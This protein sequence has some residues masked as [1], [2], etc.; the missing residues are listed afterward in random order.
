MGIR[1]RVKVA[2][3]SIDRTHLALA[4]AWTLITGAALWWHADREQ[5]FSEE[6][7]S[8]LADVVTGGVLWLLGLVGIGWSNRRTMLNKR[9]RRRAD[10]ALNE[11][12]KM[13][14]SLFE[15]AND[16]VYVVDG[17]GRYLDVNPRACA[18]TGHTYDELIALSIPDLLVSESVP[19]GLRLFGELVQNG[20]VKGDLRLQHK[21]GRSIDCELSTSRVSPDRYQAIVRDITERKL[22]EAALR[23]EEEKYRNLVESA[24]DGVLV[25]AGGKY[26][27]ANPAALRILGVSRLE[28]LL[29]RH[30]TDFL[31][32]SSLAKALERNARQ[33]AGDTTAPVAEEQRIR[34]DGTAVDV[35]VAARKV[36]YQGQSATQVI[37]RDISERKRSAEA[38]EESEARFRHL[39]ENAQDMIYRL[40]LAPTPKYEYVSPAAIALTGY[41]PNE[42]YSDPNL[43]M[44]IIHADDLPIVTH[45]LESPVPDGKPIVLRWI[46]KDGQVRWIEQEA[47]IVLDDEGKPVAIESRARD[48][49]ERRVAEQALETGNRKLALLVGELEQHGL[50]TQR[51]SE[52]SELLP[53]CATCDEAYPVISRRLR[54]YSLNGPGSCMC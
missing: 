30:F 26:V 43:A 27:F 48:I 52:M 50:E 24:H 23:G 32:P 33:E 39:A 3:Q 2:V 25:H 42:F 18:L 41:T 28:D 16:A 54:H 11:S 38:L 35:E 19:E 21:D 4:I 29:G 9:L 10:A 1:D 40:R 17:N 37:M 34:P 51:L 44:K 8:V 45:A 15:T 14:R 46:R 20:H 36:T 7:Q 47:V 6:A 22:L 49:T 13:Y 5:W 31:P 53:S 12:E